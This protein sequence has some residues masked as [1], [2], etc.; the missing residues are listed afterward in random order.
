[1]DNLYVRWVEGK[2][3]DLACWD[4]DNLDKVRPVAGCSPEVRDD[5]QGLFVDG[6][7]VPTS[8]RIVRDEDR[9]VAAVRPRAFHGPYHEQPVE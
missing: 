7:E 8:D 6:F 3:F 2:L 4:G 9:Q 5:P 1:M